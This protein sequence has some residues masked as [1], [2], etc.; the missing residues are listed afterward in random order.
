MF[1]FSHGAPEKL[2]PVLYTI[3]VGVGGSIQRS[4]F[5]FSVRLTPGQKLKAVNTNEKGN[6]QRILTVEDSVGT[7][8][9]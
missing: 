9:E 7:G 1:K 2:V 4:T 3:V 8:S 5:V 6:K